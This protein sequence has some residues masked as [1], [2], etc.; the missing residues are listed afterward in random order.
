MI[1]QK[2]PLI[3]FVQGDEWA[4]IPS[5][6]ILHTLEGGAPAPPEFPLESVTMRF[7][8]NGS[9]DI[10]ELSSAEAT[11]IE[12]VNAANWEVSVLPQIVPLLV[13]GKWTWQMRF[14]SDGGDG[15]PLTYLA[16]EVTVLETI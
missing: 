16:G 12:I 5:I 10:V 11:Q 13:A 14:W 9:P 6:S 4:G 2:L 3:T 8:R 15:N 1:P 7:L